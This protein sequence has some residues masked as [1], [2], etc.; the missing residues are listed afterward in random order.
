[1][2][3]ANS[4]GS[5]D[6]LALEVP[7]DNVNPDHICDH[8]SLLSNHKPP[9]RKTLPSIAKHPG[10]R[11]CEGALSLGYLSRS[12]KNTGTAAGSLQ[13]H[14]FNSV[15]EHIKYYRENKPNSLYSPSTETTQPQQEEGELATEPEQ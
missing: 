8:S 1:M 3:L 5:W 7:P 13:F 4:F 14:H 9:T 11:R 12:G 2:K 6:S 10:G 15:E